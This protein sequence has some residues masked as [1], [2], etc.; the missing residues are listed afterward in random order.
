[1]LLLQLE[2]I[3]LERELAYLSYALYRFKYISCRI[4]ASCNNTKVEYSNRTKIITSRSLKCC[5]SFGYFCANVLVTGW[6]RNRC[7]SCNA[8]KFHWNSLVSVS[9]VSDE[10]RFNRLRDTE[11]WKSKKR[12]TKNG[13][14]TLIRCIYRQ[15][16][17]QGKNSGFNYWGKWNAF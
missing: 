2:Q 6:H 14:E 1:M 3:H 17:I 8:C 12:L 10:Q 4:A 15:P 11:E 5:F 13:S 16:L 9:G 7:L